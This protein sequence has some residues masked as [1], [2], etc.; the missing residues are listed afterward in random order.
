MFLIINDSQTYL[1]HHESA[2]TLK[3]KFLKTIITRA[4]CD[5]SD[6]FY[7]RLSHDVIFN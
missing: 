3:L 5:H 2:H 1:L 7:F 6:I 4:V